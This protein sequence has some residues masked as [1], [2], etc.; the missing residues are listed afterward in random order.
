M[1]PESIIQRKLID[2][3]P[4]AARQICHIPSLHLDLRRARKSFEALPCNRPFASKH[5]LLC[6]PGLRH[7]DN[8][9]HHDKSCPFSAT[10]PSGQLH[11]TMTD[12]ARLSG[13]WHLLT[14]LSYPDK[15]LLYARTL[16]SPV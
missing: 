11:H 6:P 2:R 5:M 16:A 12:P 7:L 15:P 3:L 9:S 10:L 8:F 1:S 13:L 14:T 4:L